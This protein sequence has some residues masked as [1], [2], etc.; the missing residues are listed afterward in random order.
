MK[1]SEQALAR[2]DTK[3]IES[4]LSV[5]R[6]RANAIKV[7]D[8]PSYQLAAELEVEGKAYIKR[9]GFELDPGIAL[10]ADT[11]NHLRAQKAKFVDPVKAIIEQKKL[12][13]DAWKRKE[14]EAAEAEAR[15]QREEL[16][17]EQRAKAE[18]QRKAEEAAAAAL[19]K[20]REK[21]I[22]DARKAGDIKKREADRLAKEAAEG[23]RQAREA[24]AKTEA[25]AKAAPVPEVYVKPSIPTVQ[26]KRNQVN[27]KFEVTDRNKVQV[28]FLMPDEVA[29]GQKVRADKD[30]ERS[31]REIGGIRC[32]AEG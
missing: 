4:N 15:R 22:E 29:I 13:G 28:R 16:E 10:A 25:E 21:E 18:A 19:R 12:E 20:S 8:A 30:P 17:R 24:A 11:L 14:R 7:V 9:V 1:M 6:D 5:F 3:Q 32:W 31:M 23:E 27:Y 2:P 26:G